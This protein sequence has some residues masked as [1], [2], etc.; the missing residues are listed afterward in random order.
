MAGVLSSPAP[1]PRSSTDEP[2]A[3][4][5]SPPFRRAGLRPLDSSLLVDSLDM[6]YRVAL[7][8]CGSPHD[9]EDV[10]QDTCARLLSRPRYVER[11]REHSYLLV[12][13][14][15]TY[16]DRWRGRAAAPQ[17]A[18]L[19]DYA[20]VLAGPMPGPA[21]VIE[22]RAVFPAIAALPEPHRSVL[23]A[24]DVAGMSYAETAEALGVP[25]GT[26]MSRLYRA[27]SR[28]VAELGVQ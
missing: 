8:L 3:S 1:C 9:A 2:S 21:E 15:H 25:V 22:S 16:F 28:V 26:V 11:G 12:A 6:L 13:V 20:E 23:T 19:H 7:S 18:P 17:Q 5:D 14:R 24:V 4:E 27:R 10:V